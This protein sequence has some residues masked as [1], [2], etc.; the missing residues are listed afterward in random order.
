M[1]FGVATVAAGARVLAGRDTGY[2]VFRPLLIFNTAMGVAYAAAAVLI[3]RNLARGRRAA[4][5]ILALNLA[6]L[7]LVGHLF[8]TSDA[9]AVDS[10]RAMAFRSA[11]W[12]VIF[13]VLVWIGRR[14][15]LSK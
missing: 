4:G 9:V 2:V 14:Q 8:W 6:M 5:V 10:V 7:G 15:E 12:L 1:V 11:V 3:W 13:G